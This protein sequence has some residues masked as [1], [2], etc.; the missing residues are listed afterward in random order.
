MYGVR[1]LK[2]SLKLNFLAKN[3]KVPPINIGMQFFKAKG[4]ASVEMPELSLEDAM[5]VENFDLNY[6]N[7]EKG[8]FKL[9]VD[10]YS[11]KIYVLFYS[12]DDTLLQTIIGDNA[13]G[14]S[15]KIIDMNLTDNPQHVNYI[16]RELSKA[17]LCLL[18]GKPYI[19]DN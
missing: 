13:E 2:E 16:G 9:Y 15:K 14:I 4:K 10:H 12:N 18:S 8:Y 5:I 11:R 7:D 3:K 6:K 1:E 17:E 19:Q